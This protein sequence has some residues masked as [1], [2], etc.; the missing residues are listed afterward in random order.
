MIFRLELKSNLL[1]IESGLH[2]TH[3]LVLQIKHFLLT[4]VEVVL[5]E[6]LGKPFYLLDPETV[7][8]A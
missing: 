6:A 5:Q 8:M 3:T 1:E 2:S 7:H 4:L